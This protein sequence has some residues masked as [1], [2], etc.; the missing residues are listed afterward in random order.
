LI[1][2]NSKK[3][4]LKQIQNQLAARPGNRAFEQAKQYMSKFHEIA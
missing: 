1:A 4:V 2:A 3:L